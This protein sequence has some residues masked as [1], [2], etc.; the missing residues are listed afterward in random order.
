[1]GKLGRHTER[2]TAFPVTQL[3]RTPSLSIMSG[4]TWW[5]FL[6]DMGDCLNHSGIFIGTHKHGYS[7]VV[8]HLVADP[9]LWVPF[10][11]QRK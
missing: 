2:K 7:L 4:K 9:R 5:W 10:Q 3:F 1:M 8:G 11:H 6:M